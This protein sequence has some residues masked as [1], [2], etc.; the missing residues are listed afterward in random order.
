[1]GKSLTTRFVVIALIV[2]FLGWKAYEGIFQEKLE[3]GTDLKGG[4]ELVF[5][6]RFENAATGTKQQLL[7][8][9]IRVV[10]QRVDGYGLKDIDII[11]LGEDRFSLEVSARDK[12]VVESIKEL[13]TVLG[14]LEFRITVEPDGPFNY[15]KYW[16][17]F[18]AAREKGLDN[19]AF[20]RPEMLDDDDRPLAPL[21]LKWVTLSERARSETG[22]LKTRLPE[23]G[24]PWVLTIIDNYNVTGE[25]LESV[26]YRRDVDGGFT[27]GGGYAVVFN[28]ESSYHNLMSS[29]TELESDAEKK[30]MGIVLN[31]EIDS[32]P[33]L[34]SSLRSSGQITG[35]FT[36]DDAKQLAAVLQAGSLK[37]KPILVSERTIAAELAGSARN[38]GVLSTAIAFGCVLVIMA[39]LYFGPG[40]IANLALILNLVLLV[41]VLSWFEAVLTLPGIAGVLLTV[42][43]AVDANILVFERIKEE[44]AKGRTI[45]QAVETGFD[46]ALVTI[47]DANLTTLITAYFLFQIGSGPVRGFGVTLAIGILVSMF[48]ALYVS[49]TVFGWLMGRGMMTEAKMNGEYNPPK[50]DWMSRKRVAVTTSA[51]LM[52]AGALLWEGVPNLKK[53][54]LDFSEGSRLIVRFHSEMKKTDVEAKLAELAQSNDAYGDVSVRVSAEGIGTTVAEDSGRIYEFR[55]QQI[56]DEDDIEDLKN[57]FLQ[58][59]GPDL[60][61]GPFRAT[62]KEN[63]GR[64]EGRLTFVGENVE[65]AWV[66]EAIRSYARERQILR[67]LEIRKVDGVAGAGTSFDVSFSD[68]V[69]Q[70]GAIDLAVDK[71]LKEFD[72]AEYAQIM[73]FLETE[74]TKEESTE[75]QKK[76]FAERLEA[77]RAVPLP[78]NIDGL[79]ARTDPL[80]SADRVD[81][82]TARQHRDAAVRAIGLSIIGII[83]YVAFRFRSWAFGFAAVVALVHDVLVV[84]GLI[85]LINL[86]GI[87]DARLNLVTV[88]AFLTLIGYSINDTI[89]VFDR[90]R[91][92][93]TAS[94][95]RLQEIL[96][97]SINQT[98]R[99]TIRTTLTTWIVVA[100]LF[101]FNLG[102]GS[103][104]EGF[105]FILMIGVLVG[106]YS[107]I[108]IASPTLIYLPWL[109]EKSGGTPK[110]FFLRV[111]PYAAVAYVAQLVAEWRAGN[112]AGDW[113]KI[114]FTDAVLAIPMGALLLFLVQF[115]KFVREAD[116]AE[117]QPPAPA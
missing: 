33:R 94:R 42:G 17:E 59:F 65:E 50:I 112:L 46:R 82:F 54:D 15:E 7:D 102:S 51:V 100:I 29:L 3:Q 27:G 106:T 20:I 81:P 91:E 47:I 108:F 67:N 8:E 101:A 98:F 55:S 86:T 117:A 26:F 23:G 92:N 104:L 96:N 69:S 114:A 68:P 88:A 111:L 12:D 4:S 5:R 113:S 38:R 63:A 22:Y 16:R 103:P 34:N 25:A 43:M 49:R 107:S 109:W 97:K 31:D 85:A 32:A 71:A 39:W 10:Q 2:G 84:L 28:V 45:G 76:P 66:A 87:V 52:L 19:A 6:F 89:V 57:E 93:T 18:K 30:F 115:V 62:L 78:E 99:R 73:N 1:M 83:V 90:I 9:A 105:A 44:K 110:S 116:K 58:L 79:F 77:L 56:S 95:S 74:S 11:P 41:G 61:P 72:A 80:P 53:Y 35:N 21:G 14:N 60:M 48:T 13:V 36:E 24:E 37:E 64:T 70:A 40:L 75:E